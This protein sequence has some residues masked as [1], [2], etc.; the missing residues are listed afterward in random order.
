MRA[1]VATGA[2]CLRS[3]FIR[4]HHF[5]SVI[6]RVALAHSPFQVLIFT[7]LNLDS[8]LSGISPLSFD[9][10]C[11]SL[12]CQSELDWTMPVLNEK[13]LMIFCCPPDNLNSVSWLCPQ[14]LSPGSPLANPLPYSSCSWYFNLI[15]H[16]I[17]SWSQHILLLFCIFVLAVPSVCD[18]L[19][20]HL[21]LAKF[22]T[23]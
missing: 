2:E 22:L 3:S 11:P 21:H 20:P 5:I 15:I 16:F 7:L 18:S 9:L 10:L 14:T 6:F 13:S 19:S 8:S 12:C 17:F 4:I 23:L 1:H